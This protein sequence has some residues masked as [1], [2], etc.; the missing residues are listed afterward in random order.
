M[1][2]SSNFTSIVEPREPRTRVE[3]TFNAIRADI[4]DGTLEP[5]SRLA[6]DRLKDRYGVGASTIRESLSL[7]IS[8]AL[9]TAEG[10]RGFAVAPVSVEDLR[11]LSNVRVLL[12]THALRESIDKGGDDW[13]AAIVAAFHRLSKAQERVDAGEEGAMTEWEER[14]REFHAAL[15]G[16]CDSRWTRHMLAMLHH[17]TER[18]RRASLANQKAKRD[19]AGEHAEIVEATLD[20]DVERASEALARHIYRTAEVVEVITSEAS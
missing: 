16:A 11:D 1:N 7:L 3:E 17:H 19:V 15:V 20:R 9:V 10:Q 8:D 5:S 2:I 13:E 4:I 6:V 18:Y 14:N 12:E